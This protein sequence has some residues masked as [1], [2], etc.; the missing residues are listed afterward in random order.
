[1][2][3]DKILNPKLLMY[4]QLDTITFFFAHIFWMIS[5]VTILLSEMYTFLYIFLIVITIVY[6]VYYIY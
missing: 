6:G 2:E 1:M 4:N 3:T 5:H